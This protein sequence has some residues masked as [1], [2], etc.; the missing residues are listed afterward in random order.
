MK[1]FLVS[2][3]VATTIISCYDNYIKDFD[4]DAIYIPFRMDV[5]TFVVGEGMK[6][7][8]GVELGGV[9]D[10]T[11]DR[12]VSYQLDNSLITPAMLQSMKGGQAYIAAA[13]TP[14]TNLL[15]L[16]ANYFTLSNKLQFIIKKGEHIGKITVNP[17]SVKFL[18]DAATINPT[19]AIGIRLI[20]A[21]ADSLIYSKR[22]EV[23]GVKYENM[24]FGSYWHGGITTVKDPND[25]T[26]L[27]TINYYT[28][29]PVS[30]VKTW[31]LKTISPNSVAPNGYSDLTSPTGMEF[32]LS[33]NGGTVT[34]NSLTTGKYSI[35]PDGASTYNQA[36]LL[37]NRKIYLKYK[38]KDA[39]GN[40]CHA[41]DTLTFRNRMRDGVNEWQDENPSHY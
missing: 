12:I 23:I 24:L 38:Y 11:R 2:L 1:K 19:Y 21:D 26:V 41:Q 13:V 9:R 16:P 22:T 7:D 25:A 36:K 3:L 27:N 34:I 29:I 39:S 33:L 4:Y 14:V 17:D 28:T 32:S 5:R 30:D 6:F 20:S 31:S 18:S 15:P 10:N 8:I 37:Q 35:L 40:W